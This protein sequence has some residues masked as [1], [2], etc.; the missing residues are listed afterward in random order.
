M[1]YCLRDMDWDM[2]TMDLFGWFL[3]GLGF[4]FG[5]LSDRHDEFGEVFIPLNF[6]S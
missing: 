1:G 6:T 2:A 4:G 5:R 3:I